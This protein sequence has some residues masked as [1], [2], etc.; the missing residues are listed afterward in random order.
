M[1]FFRDKELAL[2]LKN[3]EVPSK[4][5]LLYLLF[6]IMLINL[7]SFPIERVK[8][9]AA[10]VYCW[11]IGTILYIIGIAICYRTNSLGDNKEFI[12]RLICLIFPVSIRVAIISLMIFCPLLLISVFILKL[13]PLISLN[14]ALAGETIIYGFFFVVSICYYFRLNKM[15]KIAAN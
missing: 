11:L 2:R 10:D 8:V 3:N 12:E 1:H 5:K 9:E 15:F 14:V 7:S 13:Y 4:E 6:Y